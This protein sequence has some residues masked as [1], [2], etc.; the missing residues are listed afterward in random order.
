M[1]GIK[2]YLKCYFYTL[3]D[4]ERGEVHTIDGRRKLEVGVKAN[5][6]L[7][8]Y[9]YHWGETSAGGAKVYAYSNC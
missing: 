3:L 5:I 1:M 6:Y 8:C 9:S 4:S 7:R 2:V